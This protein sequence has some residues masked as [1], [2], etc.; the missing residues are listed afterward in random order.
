MNVGFM[1]VLYGFVINLYGVNLCFCLKRRKS[2]KVRKISVIPQMLQSNC[3]S[4]TSCVCQVRERQELD[5]F[6]HWAKIGKTKTGQ[7]KFAWGW[8]Y[9]SLETTNRYLGLYKVFLGQRERSLLHFEH[10][11]KSWGF[12]EVWR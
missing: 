12:I 7:G 10:L 11:W 5:V 1:S 4:V 6:V 9:Q 3:S 8:D 2:A